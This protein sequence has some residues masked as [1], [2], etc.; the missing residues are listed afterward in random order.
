MMRFGPEIKDPDWMKT[1]LLLDSMNQKDL[2][3]AMQDPSPIKQ[4]RYLV[5]WVLC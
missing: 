1:L 5:K 2:R 3:K 4:I